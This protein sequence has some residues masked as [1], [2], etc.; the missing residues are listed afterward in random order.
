[1]SSCQPA[2][3]A[4]VGEF[5]QELLASQSQYSRSRSHAAAISAPCPSS[6]PPPSTTTTAAAAPPPPSRRRAEPTRRTT[7]AA[8]C[9]SKEARMSMALIL[10]GILETKV[11]IWKIL[12]SLA[13]MKDHNSNCRLFNC[14]GGE[15]G[16]PTQDTDTA[17]AVQGDENEGTSYIY[18]T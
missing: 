8:R 7:T 2:A 17:I 14:P 13:V 1:M 10:R 16:D 18:S 6:G 3:V 5:S 11:N 15:S 9:S 4:S 12:F